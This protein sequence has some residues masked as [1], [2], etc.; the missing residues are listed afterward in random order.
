MIKNILLVVPEYPPNNIWWW[1][2]VFE[3]LAIEYKK[4]WYNVLVITWD[5]KKNNIFSKLKIINENEISVLRIPEFFPPIS[6]LNTVMPYPF[7]YN[8]RI[9]S[10]I[11]DF[12][13]D[14]IS[15][16]WY[17]LFMPAQV[18]K[19]LKKLKLDYIFSIHWAPKSPEKL[20]NKILI[21]AYNFY[22]KFYGFPMLNWSKYITAVSEYAKDFE[23]FKKWKKDI[24]IIWNW[25]NPDNYKEISKENLFEKYWI[26]EEKNTKIIF[27][28]WRIEWLK[29]YDRII[30]LLPEI[31]KKGYQVKYIIAWRD[32]GEKDKLLKLSKDLGVNDNVLFIDFVIWPEKNFFLQNSDIIAI[33]SFDWETFWIVWLEWRLFKKNIITSFFWWLVD[34]L[35]WYKYAYAIEDWEKAFHSDKV[36]FDDISDFYY[37]KI[38]KKYLLLK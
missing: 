16:H 27:S 19:I 2:V 7:W 14:F 32:N 38:C 30:K 4:Q 22:H 21:S 26:K 6:L 34:S 11:K 8:F 9:K 5:Y 13:P 31:I 20:W 25:I 29:W 23:I 1:W 15:I 10:I 28:L 36:L 3:S 24:I 18:C 35:Q 12:S 17:W 33:P 37:E